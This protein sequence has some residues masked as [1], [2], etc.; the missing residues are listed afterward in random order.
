[1][2]KVTINRYKSV[3]PVGTR[4]SH[5]GYVCEVGPEGQL[6]AD[7][8]EDMLQNEL[9]HNRVTLVQEPKEEPALEDM[10]AGELIAYAAVHGIDLGGLVAQSGK[11]KILAALKAGKGE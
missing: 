9:T 11:D 3:L 7:V 10:K 1:M 6:F 8:P 4:E 2:A 5:F